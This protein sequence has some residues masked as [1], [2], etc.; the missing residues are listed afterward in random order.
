MGG[1]WLH[2]ARTERRC[3]GG[4]DAAGLV[5]GEMNEDHLDDLR[6]LDQRSIKASFASLQSC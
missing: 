5:G 3:A 1:V 2:G 4:V 6:S